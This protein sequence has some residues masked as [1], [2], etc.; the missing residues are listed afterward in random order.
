MV[1]L[2]SIGLLSGLFFSST[3][4]LNRLMSLEG[5]HWAWSASLRYIYMILLLSA[6]QIAFQGVRAFGQVLVLFFNHWKFWVLSGS[7]G[8]GSF[9]TLICFSADHAPGWVVA[10]TWQFTIIASLFV[11]IC[12]GRS[13]PKKTWIFSLIVFIGVLTVNLSH[14]NTVDIKELLL[15]GFPVLVAAFCY[16]IGNQ[17]VWEARHGRR[18]LPKIESSHLDNPFNKVLLMSLGSLPFWCVLILISSPPVPSSGQ[19]I[20]T[21]LV[22]LFSGILATSLFLYAR[23][24]A[25]RASELAAIDATQSSEVIFALI[26]EIVILHAA[27]PSGIALSGIFL[28][29]IGLSLFIRYQETA[30]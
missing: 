9:Y 29:F 26:G 10:T 8:F 7:I 23:G 19:L 13:F 4:I 15:G 11:L 27:L 3:F 24:E 14:Q 20:H 17:L 28:V 18:Y 6:G 30:N 1:K 21:A 22:A 5:G 12:F 2:I 16:P 25:K